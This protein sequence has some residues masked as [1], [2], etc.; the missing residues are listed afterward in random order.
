M[1]QV[2]LIIQVDEEVKKQFEEFCDSIGI[3][4]AIAI[5]MFIETV[6]RERR[7]PFE[8]TNEKRV[9]EDAYWIAQEEGAKSGF[10]GQ[11]KAL[12]FLKGK[13]NG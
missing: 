5:N 3:N 12:E 1:A 9:T 7:I 2:N 13:M 8:I 6:L 4:A 11:D 10:I